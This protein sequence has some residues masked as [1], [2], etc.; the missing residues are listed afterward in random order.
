MVVVVAVKIFYTL[1]NAN[2]VYPPTFYRRS[3]APSATRPQGQAVQWHPKIHDY[4]VAPNSLLP[5]L[6]FNIFVRHTRQQQQTV[7]YS[8]GRLLLY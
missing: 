1:E 2:F 6:L 7:Q 3:T 5:N 4:D 8:I